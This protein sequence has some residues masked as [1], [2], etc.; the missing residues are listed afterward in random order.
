MSDFKSQIARHRDKLNEFHERIHSTFKVRN[1]S[2][3]HKRR[4]E[5]A[6]ADF[7][8][9]R[10]EVDSCM[11]QVRVERLSEDKQIRQFVFDFLTVDP[12]YFRSGYEKENL[13]RLIKSLDLLDGEKDVLRQT[14]LRRVRNGALREFRR[15]CQLIPKIEN[16]AFVAKL[17]KEARSTDAQIQ[18]RAAFALKYV[19]EKPSARN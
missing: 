10:S 8:G 13:I 11:D 15:F 19:A 14:I 9:F 3:A 17:R 2:E 1:C 7:H 4:W 18:R 6:C 12:I 16:D 5:D